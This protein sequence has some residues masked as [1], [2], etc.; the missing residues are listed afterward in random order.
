MAATVQFVGV[1]T[2]AAGGTN[3]TVNPGYPTTQIGDLILLVVSTPNQA[4]AAP[5]ADWTEIGIQANTGTGTAGNANAIRVAVF[6]RFNRTGLTGTQAVAGTWNVVASQMVAF[7]NVDP[8]RPFNNNAQGTQA[9]AATTF[10]CTAVTST[11]PNALIVNCMGNDQDGN[12]TDGIINEANANLIGFGTAFDRT[13]NTNTGTGVACF[14]GR[15]ANVGSSG[16]TTGT[17]TGT[18]ASSQSAFNTL[19]I[20]PNRRLMVMIE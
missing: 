14:Y 15:L 5:S 9:A 17:K 1:G 4:I 7:R 8:I 16:N 18:G 12:V 11:I 13:V 10:S 19:A 2:F 6:Y 3:V 20:R